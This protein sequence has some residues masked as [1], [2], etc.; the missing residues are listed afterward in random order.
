MSL[1]GPSRSTFLVV[2]CCAFSSFRVTSCDCHASS[3]FV[4][5]SLALSQ[6]QNST[7]SRMGPS[8]HLAGR[9][10]EREFD[11]HHFPL[12]CNPMDE[13]KTCTCC[14]EKKAL[15]E[16]PLK[17]REQLV[18]RSQC[19]QC[20]YQK[21]KASKRAWA[22]ANRPRI[23]AYFKEWKSKNFERYKMTVANW[24]LNR[25]SKVAY[26]NL[27]STLDYPPVCLKHR[28][29]KMVFRCNLH[30]WVC[31]DCT[32]EKRKLRR[33]RYKGKRVTRQFAELY[34]LDWMD[35]QLHVANSNK[36][37]SVARRDYLKTSFS[38]RHG[39]T[40]TDKSFAKICRL[41]RKSAK[42]PL[43]VGWS[44]NRC[45]YYSEDPGFFDLHHIVA[46]VHKGQTNDD[47]LEILCPNCHR[48][49]TLQFNR[50]LV[51]KTFF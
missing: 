15:T 46:R 18:Y 37:P 8:H 19:K 35:V 45:K 17:S 42:H 10:P 44:C 31:P 3:H 2:G 25:G 5:P 28:Q 12:Y 39:F 36:H 9:R 40:A 41:N 13:T 30:K 33:S 49:E 43:D 14:N 48:I 50:A 6:S 26:E 23:A 22:V 21:T 51:K 27:E 24:K 16:F 7:F 20:Y 38:Q 4:L 34:G 1:L 32:K 11:R 29:S 47:N